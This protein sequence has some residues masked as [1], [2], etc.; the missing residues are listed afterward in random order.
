[1]AL[2]LERLS[3]AGIEIHTLLATGGGALSH[4][5]LQMKADIL[6]R[7][8]VSL[9]AAQSGTLGCIM[10]AGV[11]CGIYSSLED[12]ESVYVKVRHTYTPDSGKHEHYNKWYNKYKKCYE[13]VK[14][15]M[16]VD[17]EV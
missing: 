11:A 1:M 5:W 9:G 3:E 16:T 15:V 4:I 13:A 7:P 17:Q 10:L 12:A 8:I 6:N 14:S 2:N